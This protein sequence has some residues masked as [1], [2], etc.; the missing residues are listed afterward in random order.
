MTAAWRQIITHGFYPI[1]TANHV[2]P[3][4]VVALDAGGAVL[5]YS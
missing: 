2:L 1:K 4:A 3:V 5:L